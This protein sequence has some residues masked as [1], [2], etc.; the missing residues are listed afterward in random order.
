MMRLPASCQM[1][2]SWTAKTPS[3]WRRRALRRLTSICLGTVCSRISADSFRSGYVVYR[4]IQTMMRQ[5]VGSRYRTQQGPAVENVVLVLLWSSSPKPTSVL[6]WWWWSLQ[7]V[8]ALHGLLQGRPGSHGRHT[9]VKMMA[10]TTTMTEPSA[11]PRTWRKTPR[12][13]SWDEE[14]ASC[15]WSRSCS[16]S[17]S[18]F[19]CKADSSATPKQTKT[20]RT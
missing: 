7:C 4:S 15:S 13:F 10:L 14:D 16:W 1:W 20:K 2:S 8:L 6:F 12:M 17:N 5:R 3:S 11:S 19:S 18:P 9:K